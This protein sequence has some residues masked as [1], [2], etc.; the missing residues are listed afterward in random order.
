MGTLVVVLSH[1][2][3]HR[4]AKWLDMFSPAHTFRIERKCTKDAAHLMQHLGQDCTKVAPQKTKCCRVS[5]CSCESFFM[6]EAFV[7]IVPQLSRMTKPLGNVTTVK[8]T[9]LNL[10][11]VYPCLR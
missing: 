2:L 7:L 10:R 11:C 1:S 4:P 3:R 9:G 8:C 5:E 6:R